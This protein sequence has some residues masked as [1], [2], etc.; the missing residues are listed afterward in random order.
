M[1]F[2][3]Q[4]GKDTWGNE[5]KK[6]SVFP[7]VDLLVLLY[8]DIKRAPMT[9]FPI[10]KTITKITP[11]TVLFIY[12]APPGLHGLAYKEQFSSLKIAIPVSA[13]NKIKLHSVVLVM[14][15][16]KL[17]SEKCVRIKPQFHI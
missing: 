13:E 6:S 16:K 15:V 11:H 9:I 10:F 7:L 2:T 3:V 12:T 1:Q 8:I 14:G 17:I 5:G 4:K